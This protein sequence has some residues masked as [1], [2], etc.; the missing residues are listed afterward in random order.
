MFGNRKQYKRG[1]GR[2]FPSESWYK[3]DIPPNPEHSNLGRRPFWSESMLKDDEL[4]M[5]E[6]E[7][8]MLEDEL[9]EL[10]K[11]KKKLI[12]G[13]EKNAMG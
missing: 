2:R 11:R 13:G 7:E 6:E 4:K 5:L 1:Q 3:E 9:V 10:R 12:N 8:A